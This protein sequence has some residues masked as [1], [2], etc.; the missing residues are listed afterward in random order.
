V[1][2]IGDRVVRMPEN[3]DYWWKEHV[4]NPHEP[5]SVTSI[6]EPNRISVSDSMP[7]DSWY[8][9][10]FTKLESKFKK[11]ADRLNNASR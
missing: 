11:Y 1:F 7:G 3:Q 5:H 8:D 2:K 10:K 6:V 4:K 9:F